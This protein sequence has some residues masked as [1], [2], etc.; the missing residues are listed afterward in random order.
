[1]FPPSLSLGLFPHPLCLS[2]AHLQDNELS[3][4]ELRVKYGYGDAPA[5]AASSATAGGSSTTSRSRRR[6]NQGGPEAKR[7]KSADD[8]AEGA[9]ANSADET[10]EPDQ[11]ADADGGNDAIL[12]YAPDSVI[13]RAD[14]EGQDDEDEALE[15]EALDDEDDD[16]DEIVHVQ[17]DDPLAY[18]IAE[19]ER[20]AIEADEAKTLAKL[21]EVRSSKERRDGSEGG[22]YL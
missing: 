11:L 18:Y 22:R 7:V 6:R 15:D 14:D 16:D 19:A 3:V 9:A 13:D 1:M 12:L 20:E 17:P 5:Y 4:D 2:L 10:A 8:A 21:R